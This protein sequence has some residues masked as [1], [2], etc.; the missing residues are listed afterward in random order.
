MAPMREKDGKSRL[1]N[2]IKELARK[3]Q[4]LLAHLEG[5]TTGTGKFHTLAFLEK[6]QRDLHRALAEQNNAISELRF[7]QLEGAEHY[8]SYG[9]LAGQRPLRETV[10]DALE[11][12]HVPCAPRTIAEFVLAR[13]AITIPTS[14][15][16]SLR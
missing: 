10:L 5:I 12:L 16:A 2:R 14:R 8:G 6:T 15:F 13:Y 1:L 4:E 3:Q 11:E 9:R 7:L